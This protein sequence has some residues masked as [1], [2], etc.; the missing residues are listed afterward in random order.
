MNYYIYPVFSSVN[1]SSNT[2][3]STLL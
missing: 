2:D 3:T 1:T